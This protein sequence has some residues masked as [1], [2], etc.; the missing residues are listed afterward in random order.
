IISTEDRVSVHITG[1]DFLLGNLKF[2]PKR[3]KD[4]VFGNLI[5]K[6]LITEAIQTSP[7]YQQYLEMIDRKS[8]LQLIDEHNEEPQPAPEPQI[9]DDEYNLQRGI[10][11]SLE[12]F[13]ARVGGVA[14]REPTLAHGQEPVGGVAIHEPVLETTRKLLVTEGKGKGIATNEQVA[15]SLLEIQQPKGKRKSTTDQYIFQMRALVTKEASTGPLAQPKDDTFANIDRNTPSPPNDATGV[16][17]KMSNSKG[18]TEMLNVGKDKGED[19]SNI[20]ALK[21]RIVELDEGQARSDPSNTLGPNPE[22]MHKDFITTVYPKVYKSLKHTTEEHVFLE[23]LPSSSRILS[24]IK[25]L[26]D[27]F[28]YGDQFLYDKPTEKEPGKANVETKVE[29]MV[30]IPIHQASSTV[31]PLSTPIIDLT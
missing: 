11:M 2:I 24:S 22:P 16:E 10:Q 14:I 7:Y 6:E 21:E 19:V 4:E 3:E 17:A 30:T 13:Q 23:N 9:E 1:D 27:A 15:Q 12:S 29:S 26:D 28:T 5:P 8:S 31:P 25:N 20:M 18:N